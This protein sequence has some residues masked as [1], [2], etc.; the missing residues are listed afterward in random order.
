MQESSCGSYVV[1]RIYPSRYVD[2]INDRAFLVDF[3]A[4]KY[5]AQLKS[6]AH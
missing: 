3:L 2:Y 5:G 4:M 6:E 1:Y